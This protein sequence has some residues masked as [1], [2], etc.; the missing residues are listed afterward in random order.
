MDTDRLFNSAVNFALNFGM[1]YGIARL[2]RG[3][4]A[5]VRAGAAAGALSAAASWRL[6]GRYEDERGG[7]GDVEGVTVPIE[8]PS[9]RA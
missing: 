4:R 9:A 2:F 1:A 6:W 8:E 3:H 7:V 5:A